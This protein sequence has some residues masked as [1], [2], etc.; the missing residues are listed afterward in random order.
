M[1]NAQVRNSHAKTQLSRNMPVPTKYQYSYEVPVS[2]RQPFGLDRGYEAHI[3]E[4]E[5]S[6]EGKYGVSFNFKFK[7]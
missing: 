6:W 5:E 1:P 7:N 3:C 2:A 4:G